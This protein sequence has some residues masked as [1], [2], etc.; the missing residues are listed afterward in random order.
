[1]GTCCIKPECCS[2][3][4]SPGFT[5]VC[6]RPSKEWLK[7]YKLKI[8][9]EEKASGVKVPELSEQAAQVELDLEESTQKS[10]L[11]DKANAEERHLQAMLKPGESKKRREAT[12][13]TA[14]GQK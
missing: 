13:L 10:E 3:T 14:T 12:G 11:Q 2:C 9:E 7:N 4:T 6:Q 1:M 8:R 5:E